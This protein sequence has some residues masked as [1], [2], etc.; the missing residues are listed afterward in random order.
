MNG[1]FR[2]ACASLLQPTITC[3]GFM[4]GLL[5]VKCDL[6]ER[7]ILAINPVKYYVIGCFQYITA[8]SQCS[9]CVLYIH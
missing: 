7:I 5:F 3:C 9:Y 6:P 4:S 2:K 8:E 1:S